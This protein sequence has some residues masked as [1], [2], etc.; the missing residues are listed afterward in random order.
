M[1]PKD[2]IHLLAESLK[3]YTSSYGKVI[4]L[5]RYYEKPDTKMFAIDV[6]V[7]KPDNTKPVYHI[8]FDPKDESFHWLDFGVDVDLGNTVE[9]VIEAFEIMLEE[10]APVKILQR[11]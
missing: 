8:D 7:A 11:R 4:R 1:N 5:K 10:D 6:E 9:D 2:Q 3:D